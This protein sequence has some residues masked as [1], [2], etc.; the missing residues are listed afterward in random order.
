MQKQIDSYDEENQKLKE[1]NLSLEKNI[2]IL[3][4][5]RKILEETISSHAERLEALN[6]S[7]S[8]VQTATEKDHTKFATQVELFIAEVKKLQETHSQFDKTGSS[9][10][11]TIDLTMQASEI[12]QAI[13][14]K[15]NQWK[16]GEEIVRLIQKRNKSSKKISLL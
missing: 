15:I 14:T 3:K 2:K 4:E 16:D 1:T 6:A 9:F 12:L 13:F 11:K 7:L 10:E 5:T 8:G